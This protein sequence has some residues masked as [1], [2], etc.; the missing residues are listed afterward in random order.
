MSA[1][2]RDG[3][4]YDSSPIR[5]LSST[6]VVEAGE[7]IEGTDDLRAYL[8]HRGRDEEGHD[9]RQPGLA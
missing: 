8:I 6:K 7:N 1:L 4:N 9:A 3:L 2:R 5:H